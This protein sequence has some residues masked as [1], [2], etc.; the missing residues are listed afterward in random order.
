[1][2]L[3]SLVVVHVVLRMCR[4]RGVLSGH[5]GRGRGGEGGTEERECE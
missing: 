3:V 2:K 1:M 4:G 5:G